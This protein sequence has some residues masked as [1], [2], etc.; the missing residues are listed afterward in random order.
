MKEKNLLRCLILNSGLD[1]KPSDS[2]ITDTGLSSVSFHT[3]VRA[4]RL[5]Q[6]ALPYKITVF[7][8]KGVLTSFVLGSLLEYSDSSPNSTHMLILATKPQN[9]VT[10]S[11][12]S[13]N[14]DR[15]LLG[16]LVLSTGK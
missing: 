7:C 11:S 12:H 4:Q 10:G 14:E 13:G 9:N 5:L 3:P 6:P 16:S 15:N 1:A 2:H 8:T